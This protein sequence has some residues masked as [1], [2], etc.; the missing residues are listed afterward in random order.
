MDKESILDRV[1]R[2]NLLDPDQLSDE[3]NQWL[4]RLKDLA[5]VMSGRLQLKHREDKTHEQH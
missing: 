5:A 2:L 4:H 3:D 1:L